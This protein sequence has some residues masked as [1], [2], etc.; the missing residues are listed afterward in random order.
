MRY[1]ESR[2]ELQTRDNAYRI[3]IS[4]A[5]KCIGGLDKRYY[6]MIHQNE[7][8]SE[9]DAEEMEKDIYNHMDNI[10]RNIG[11]Q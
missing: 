3:Y 6:D 7:Q 2:Y 5:L 9:E 10:L 1:V 8:I 11:G 4:D